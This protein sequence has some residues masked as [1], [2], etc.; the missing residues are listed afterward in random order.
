MVGPIEV[1]IELI[2]DEILAA[3]VEPVFR[4][5]RTAVSEDESREVS[6]DDWSASE[7][8][9]GIEGGRSNASRD[10]RSDFNLEN[11]VRPYF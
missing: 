2:R 5:S 9:V 6:I 7:D 11:T 4:D 10:C 3:F 8:G 1:V